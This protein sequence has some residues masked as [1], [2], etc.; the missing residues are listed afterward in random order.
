MII[1]RGF[2]KNYLGLF[3]WGAAC[4]LLMGMGEIGG[5]A[6]L[7]KI[8]IPAKDFKVEIIDQIGVKTN[9]TK[10]SQ[11]GRVVLS[12]MRG[13]AQIAIPFEII[14][15]IEFIKLEGQEVILKVFLR[16]PKSYEIKIEKKSKF[17]GQADFGP[18]RIEVQ[19]IKMINFLL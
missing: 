3:F 14:S 9:L 2:M 1:K 15:K 6:P 18:L 12:G 5:T 16:E 17:F 8:P 19:D 10:F 13:Q 7:E 4:L 11:E